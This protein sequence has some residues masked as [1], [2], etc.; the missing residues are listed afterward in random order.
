VESLANDERN[1]LPLV[2]FPDG[3]RLAEPSPLAIAERIGLKTRASEA[4]YDLAIVGAG[5]A[6]LAAAVYGASE[7]LRTI[8]IDRDAPGGQ[9]GLSSRIEN[10]LGFPSGLSGGDLARRAVVQAKRLGAEVLSPQEVVALRAD[11][12]Y[13]LIRLADGSEI[14]CHAVV[15]ATGV[16]WR[17]L[18]VPD[19]ER[20]T[21]AGVYYGASY[22]DAISCRDEDVYVVGGAN[23]AGQAAI[24]FSKYARHVGL[25]VRGNC[26][27]SSMSHYLTA[28]IAKTPNITVELNTSLRAVHGRD[29]LETV[30]IHAVNG[31]TKTVITSALFIFIGAVPRTD[32]LDGLVERDARGFILCGP[33]LVRDGKRPAGWDIDRDPAL[34]ETSMP[35]VFAVGDVRSGSVKRVAAGVGEG[36]VAIS[37]IHQHLQKM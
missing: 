26:L 29:H 10:Y 14:S 22:A 2:I 27:S 37:F 28:E 30:T 8:L 15:I 1:R 17:K 36:S 20:L 7:G 34:L 13:R 6:G 31:E 5:P 12:L 25:L 35:G 21:G 16:Q 11:G 4:F 19:I 18:D 24:Y 33:D 23:S 32:W 3:T 9:A